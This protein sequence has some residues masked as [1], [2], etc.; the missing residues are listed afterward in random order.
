MDPERSHDASVRAGVFA[1]MAGFAVFLLIHHLWIVPIWF[2]APIGGLL[3]VAG[4]AAV[5]AAYAELLP[6]LPQR[7]W[8]LIAVIGVVVVPILPA[9]ILAELRGPIF[10]MD[11]SGSGTF[12]A[13]GTE[14]AVA[15]LVGLVGTATIAGAGLGWLI[16]RSRRAAGTLALA[17]FVIA[18]GPGH[19]IPLLGGTGV[20]AKEL[21]IL[22]AVIGVA[23]FA[24]VEG[25]NWLVRRRHAADGSVAGPG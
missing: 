1:G 24:L 6:H 5:G 14:V 12:L 19:N 11:R 17:A 20:V 8:T 25:H 9:I 13:P 3:A 16:A 22:A 7:P 23:S 15:F 18:L 4:G 10:V 2:I 21:A